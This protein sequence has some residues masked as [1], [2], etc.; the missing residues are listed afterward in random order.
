MDSQDWDDVKRIF[1][2]LLELRPEERESYL[3]RGSTLNG[4]RNGVKRSN[5]AWQLVGCCRKCRIYIAEPT[6]ESF[7]GLAQSGNILRP[8]RL[9]CHALFSSAQAYQRVIDDL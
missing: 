6:G 7:R 1:Q 3:D 5:F 2:E 4:K 8:S 9:H